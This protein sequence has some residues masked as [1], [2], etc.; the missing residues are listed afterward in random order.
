MA[1]KVTWTKTR[2]R[3]MESKITWFLEPIV[4]D[5]VEIKDEDLRVL[6][7]DHLAAHLL[8]EALWLWLSDVVRHDER[9]QI[10]SSIRALVTSTRKDRTHG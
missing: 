1:K 7:K 4:Q 2:Q 6:T 10:S 8:Y 9:E 3:E 5:I